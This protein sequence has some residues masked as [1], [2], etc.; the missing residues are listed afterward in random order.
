MSDYSH[1]WS[2]SSCDKVRS[3][4]VHEVVIVPLI[5]MP[6]SPSGVS[7]AKWEENLNG[8]FL[9][10]MFPEKGKVRFEL[11]KKSTLFC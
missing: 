9:R 1:A 7:S 4:V 3:S 8:V 5:K 2:L 10:K 11:K 6:F